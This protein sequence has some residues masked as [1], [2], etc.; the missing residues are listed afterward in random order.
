M[1]W[2]SSV[3]RERRRRVQASVAAYAYELCDVAIM[4][5]T[6]FDELVQTIN[7]RLT[8][9]HPLIDE[10]FL[11]KFSPMTG[12]WIHEHPELGKIKALFENY[13]QHQKGWCDRVTRSN[14]A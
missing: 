1:S 13:Y 4:L 3:E 12:M 8:T 6:H 7:P 9:G 5:D 11:T 2:G 14:R 10:F